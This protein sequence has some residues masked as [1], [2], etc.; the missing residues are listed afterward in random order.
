MEEM[1]AYADTLP[2][3]NQI[4]VRVMLSRWGDLY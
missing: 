2:S 4:E 3:V 1:K